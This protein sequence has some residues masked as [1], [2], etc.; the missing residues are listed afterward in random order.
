VTQRFR[1]EKRARFYARETP[2]GFP[3]P[4][5]VY[6]GR[7]VIV[8]IQPGDSERG[9]LAATLDHVSPR[10][11]NRPDEVLVSCFECNTSKGD[12]EP[13]EWEAAGGG[14]WKATDRRPPAKT[15]AG[16]VM[17]ALARPLCGR[18][19]GSCN[20]LVGELAAERAANAAAQRRK[21]RRR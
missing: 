14:R 15:L 3:G 20:L 19:S 16:R 8:G 12:R 2:E 11:G 6:C 13:E 5:C 1:D 9:L 17:L 21:R 7:A 18:S 4:C 10:G